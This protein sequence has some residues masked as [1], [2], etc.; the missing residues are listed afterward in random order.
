[1]Q[2]GASLVSSISNVILILIVTLIAKY[3][4]KSDNIPKEYAFI[5]TA[6]LIS[7]YINSSILPLVMNGSIFGF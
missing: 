6:V 3:V 2:I 5:F 4:L 7:N 1:M